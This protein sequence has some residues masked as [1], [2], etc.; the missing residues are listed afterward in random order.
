MQACGVSLARL[1]RP[2]GVVAV[3]RLGGDV[4]RDARGAARRQPDVPRDHVQRRRRSGPKARS[5]RASSSTS[6]P[7]L[8][9]YVRDVPPAGG[10]N[11]V[12]MADS[13]PGQPA[14]DLPGAARAAS[15]SIARSAR[16]RWCSRTATRHVADRRRQVRGRRVR[17][18]RCVQRRS[19]HRSFRASGPTKGDH[20]M[21][22][23]ELRA[24]GGG[25]RE[26]Q[27]MS[28]HNQIMAIH[29]KFSIPVACLVFGVIGLAL[30]ATNRRDGK[31]GSFVFGLGVIFV[32][33]VPLYARA[34]A[35]EGAS[36]PAVAGGLAA[37]HRP[38]AGSASCCSSGAIARRR[39][40]EFRLARRRWL[41]RRQRPRPVG[42]RCR[43]T[44]ASA[45]GFVPIP[46]P[47]ILDRYVASMYVRVFVLCGGRPGRASSTSR[48]SSTC[49]TRC[50][51]ARRR[52]A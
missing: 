41:Q 42:A 2:V 28:S 45:L 7:N 21:T 51:R 25:A 35:G 16:S 24:R 43:S 9:L 31:L 19:R 27:G 29:Q 18:G 12:F 44:L 6:F 4:V 36:D 39:P 3:A 48:R 5:S 33:Y 46:R 38:R 22:I 13:R 1:L 47:S 17:R 11:D 50:S 15:C 37:E 14:G 20:E 52:G 32:Y 40:A 10:W 26:A 34:G 49:R 23:A 8:V 30:G